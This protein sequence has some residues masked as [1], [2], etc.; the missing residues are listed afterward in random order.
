VST[1]RPDRIDDNFTDT[2]EDPGGPVTWSLSGAFREHGGAVTRLARRI[3]GPTLALDVTQEV[4]LRLWIHPEK[5]DPQRGSL[6]GYLLM[7]TRHKSIDAIR[8]EAA[9]LAR[10]TRTLDVPAPQDETPADRVIR[11]D[12]AAQVS[13]GLDHLSD[14]QRDAIVLA[15]YGGHSYRDVAVILGEPEGTIKARIRVGLQRLRS[16]LAALAD[17]EPAIDLMLERSRRAAMDDRAAVEQ[18][19]GAVSRCS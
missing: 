15:F 17:A 12:R 18:P 13:A 2:R 8:S 4:F 10:D 11:A 14:A 16:V 9:R 1:H 7:V 3:C 6:L 5:F 19:E